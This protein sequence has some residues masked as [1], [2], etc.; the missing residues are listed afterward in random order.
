MASLRSLHSAQDNVRV[1]VLGHTCGK[2]L[3]VCTLILTVFNLVGN[4]TAQVCI[5]TLA[6][7]LG[8]RAFP[9]L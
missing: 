5:E 8:S 9:M 6:L 1:Q 4:G 7:N 2:W 3:G